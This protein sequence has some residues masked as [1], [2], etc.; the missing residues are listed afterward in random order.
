MSDSLI[1]DFGG[2][3]IA[4]AMVTLC[5]DEAGG[6]NKRVVCRIT[7]LPM[8]IVTHILKELFDH[9]VIEYKSPVWVIKEMS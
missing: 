2:R 9:N 5:I 6:A 7:G 4:R 3:N 1:T 8:E